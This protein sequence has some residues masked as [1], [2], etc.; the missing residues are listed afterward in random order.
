MEKKPLSTIEDAL[1]SETT[2]Q[3]TYKNAGKKSGGG[4][5]PIDEASRRT[6]ATGL[7]LNL[8]EHEKLKKLVEYNM[9]DNANSYLRKLLLREYSKTFKEE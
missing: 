8:K 3:K 7:M 9:E 5:K 4:R 2:S 1:K 6:I